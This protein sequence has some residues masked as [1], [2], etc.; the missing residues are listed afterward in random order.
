MTQETKL[1]GHIT[2][3]NIKVGGGF[4]RRKASGGE[5]GDRNGERGNG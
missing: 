4:L 3:D 5:V 1:T 2:K